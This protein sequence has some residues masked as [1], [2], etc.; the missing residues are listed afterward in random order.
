MEQR[1]H[2]LDRESVLFSSGR[3][4][5]VPGGRRSEERRS[6]LAASSRDTSGRDGEESACERDD[7]TREDC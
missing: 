6:H 5:R 4:I 1:F 3:R 2:S 7:E